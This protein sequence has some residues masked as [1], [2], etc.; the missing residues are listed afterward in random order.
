MTFFSKHITDVED[1]YKSIYNTYR[2]RVFQYIRGKVKDRNDI[3]DIAQNVFFH[4]WEYRESLGGANTENIIFKTCNQEISKFFKTQRKHVFEKNYNIPE[5]PDDAV[6]QLDSK[7]IKEQQ[8][9]AMQD[10]IELLPTS[11]KKMFTMNKL[12]GVTQEKIAVQLNL[13]KKIV[14]K[15][16]SDALVFLQNFHKNS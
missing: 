11:S 4:L 12:E 8:L 13:S 1:M 5:T 15:Q 10:S 14:Q 2:E 6:D 9:Q 7:L 3:R 16:I